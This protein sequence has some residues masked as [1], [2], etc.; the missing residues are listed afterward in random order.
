[1][2]HSP[3]IRGG[4]LVD[5]DGT[6]VDSN[7]LHV[8]AW[9]RAFR[10]CGREIRMSAIHRHVGMGS[11]QLIKAL[12]GEEDE[13][14][15]ELH[16]QEY[17]PLRDDI[18]AFQHA[19]DLLRELHRLGMRIV[20]AT[21]AKEDEMPALLGAI[22]AEEAIHEIV[23]SKQVPRSKP[24]PDIFKVALEH[25]RLPPERT[26]CIGDTVWDVEAARRIGLRCVCV[27]T[28]GISPA[29]LETAGAA[30]VYEDVAGLLERLNSSPI[31]ELVRGRP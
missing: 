22:G 2:T 7:Y 29:E 15:S 8:L 31:G 20:L 27:G 16:S 19:G 11:D 1:L 14:L 30:A 23:S 18:H 28:G 13:V 12:T 4:V 17:A 6:L 26:I 10:K 9:Y 5:L 25:C 24:A 3:D 21:S